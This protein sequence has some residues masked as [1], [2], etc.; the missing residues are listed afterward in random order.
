MTANFLLEDTVKLSVSGPAPV[1]L[2]DFGKAG[3]LNDLE[4]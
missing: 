1:F 2:E 3:P 4:S